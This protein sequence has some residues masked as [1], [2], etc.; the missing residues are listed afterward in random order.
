MTF[1]KR[2]TTLNFSYC[3]YLRPCLCDWMKSE[4][5]N[6]HPVVKYLAC[7]TIYL[8]DV[9]TFRIDWLLWLWVDTVWVTCC[10]S[11]QSMAVFPCITSWLM[12]VPSGTSINH[13][14]LIIGTWVFSG[15]NDFLAILVLMTLNTV[16][17]W[18][19][20]ASFLPWIDLKIQSKIGLASECGFIWVNTIL[21][22]DGGGLSTERSWA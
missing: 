21:E 12:L 8:M 22:H 6:Y 9:S 11:C 20:L 19:A 14:S 16:S 10:S 17:D 2:K 4:N 7:Q 15:W 5:A 18:T 13:D 1:R 3:F